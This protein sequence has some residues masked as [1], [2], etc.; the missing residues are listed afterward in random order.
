MSMSVADFGMGE[1][2]EDRQVV[3]QSLERAHA[4]GEF[5]FLS[6]SNWKPEPVFIGRFIRQRHR[7]AIGKVKTGKP[8]GILPFFI[9]Y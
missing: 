9:G 7:H 3:A 4:P 6:V 2:R 8:L 1:S 5:E